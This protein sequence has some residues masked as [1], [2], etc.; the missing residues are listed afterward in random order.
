MAEVDVYEVEARSNVGLDSPV[1]IF[2]IIVAIEAGPAV[3]STYLHRGSRILSLH[4]SDKVHILLRRPV[5]HIAASMV[6]LILRGDEHQGY[7]EEVRVVE[8]R[9]NDLRAHRAYGK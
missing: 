9:L 1:N 6:Y 8:Y 2:N 7:A 4:I 3:V 5:V